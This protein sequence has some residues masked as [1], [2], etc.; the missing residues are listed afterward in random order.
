MIASSVGVGYPIMY[1]REMSKPAL[2][3]IGIIA[4]GII[5]LLIDLFMQ[6]LQDK[7]I[8]WELSR[9]GKNGT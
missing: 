2:L 8:F 7:I 6:F 3:F 5:G 1:A 4:I 9:G